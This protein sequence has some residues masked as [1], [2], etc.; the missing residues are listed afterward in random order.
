MDKQQK[1]IADDLNKLAEK[2]KD[3]MIQAGKHVAENIFVHGAEPYQAMNISRSKMEG[4]YAQGYQL[5]NAG[6][7]EKAY[8]TFELLAQLHPSDPRF[9]FGMA[10]CLQALKNFEPAYYMFLQSAMGDPEN[11]VPLY[12]AV[13]CCLQKGE[14][15]SALVMVQM[16]LDRAKDRAEFSYIKDRCTMLKENLTAELNAE[17]E[18]LLKK[19]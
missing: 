10:A 12:H 1:K 4:I 18:K 14:K 7:F 15:M 19:K 17:G 3:E 2:Y 13:D 6:N 5:Y 8:K 9:S 16:V 11:P